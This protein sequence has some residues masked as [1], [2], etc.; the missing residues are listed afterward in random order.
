MTQ[1][2]NLDLTD[3][4]CKYP[5]DVVK[6]VL[7]IICAQRDGIVRIKYLEVGSMFCPRFGG[8]LLKT[9]D[10]NYRSICRS[11]KVKKI[12]DIEL[13]KFLKYQL[14]VNKVKEKYDE[15]KKIHGEME[16]LQEKRDKKLKE[17]ITLSKEIA[18]GLEGVYVEKVLSE[19]NIRV[20]HL[21]EEEIRKIIEFVKQ[22]KSTP[23]VS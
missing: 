17:D 4:E 9:Y 7:D 8:I 21:T 5:H 1:Y 12:N 10:S 2:D 6:K 18:Q 13:K 23:K 15:L 3:E 11:V 22:M 19:F 20:T 14:D 16:F